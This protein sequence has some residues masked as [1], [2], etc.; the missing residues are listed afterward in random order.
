MQLKAHLA[1]PLLPPCRPS[2]VRRLR[3]VLVAAC[4]LAA[5]ARVRVAAAASCYTVYT[6]QSWLC[7]NLC[8]YE[9]SGG[10]EVILDTADPTTAASQCCSAC[11]SAMPAC[12][13]W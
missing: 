9:I 5:A 4:L 10:G 1:P 2:P 12:T 7:P 13:H 3:A 6:G 11:L 8:C